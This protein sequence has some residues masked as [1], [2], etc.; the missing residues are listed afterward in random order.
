MEFTLKLWFKNVQER[1]LAS[2]V[3]SDVSKKLKIYYTNR[4]KNNFV[5]QSMEEKRNNVFKITHNEDKDADFIGVE[6]WL[7]NER[8]KIQHEYPFSSK[9]NINEMGLLVSCPTPK[10]KMFILD[11]NI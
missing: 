8:P 2:T 11:I 10:M 4:K 6:N 7:N 1:M 9:Y 3:Q 5:A